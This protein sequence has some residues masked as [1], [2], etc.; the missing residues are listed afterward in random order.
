MIEEFKKLKGQANEKMDQAMQH[1]ED[2]FKKLK[3]GR[4]NVAMVEDI[5]F[6]YFGNSVPIKQSAS[7]TTPDPH[8]IV[9]TPWDKSA[10]HAIEK[11]IADANIGFTANNDGKVIR[12]S[13]PP[14]T[15]DRKKELVKYAKELAEETKIVI[16]NA[17]RDINDRVKKMTKEGHFSEDDER[18]ELNDIQKVTDSHIKKIEQVILAKEKDIMEV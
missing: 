15:E 11:G 13:V 6:E 3:T 9:I 1:L 16:R 17:R 12:V 4:A 18:K 2:E 10:L 8:S 7:L 14:L 5:K